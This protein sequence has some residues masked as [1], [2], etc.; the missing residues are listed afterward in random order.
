MDHRST[1]PH[2][3]SQ[4][5]HPAAS[6][7]STPRRRSHSQPVAPAAV[8]HLA[9]PYPGP[10][11]H[12]NRAIQ[13]A[14]QFDF[15]AFLHQV[16]TGP[17]GYDEDLFAQ[18]AS[19]SDEQHRQLPTAPSSSSAFQPPHTMP[20]LPPQLQQL[21][22]QH[23][24]GSGGQAP[25]PLLTQTFLAWLQYMHLQNQLSH[26]NPQQP[27]PHP[28]GAPTHQQQPFL[29]PNIPQTQGYPQTLQLDASTSQAGPSAPRQRRASTATQPQATDSPGSEP[30]DGEG[31]QI[32][33]AEDKRRRNTA[34]SARFRVKKKQWTLNLERS[35]TDLSGRVEELEREAAELRRENGW[36]KEIVMLKS[37]RFG[38]GA[39]SAEQEAS[40]SSSEE[41]RDE[42]DREGEGSAEQDEESHHSSSAGPDPVVGKG[43]GRDI[44]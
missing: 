35:I 31:D 24:Q 14:D 42:L 18:L 10:T 28:S 16:P 21:Q 22:H 13:P 36:L 7:N 2:P 11:S 38:S 32:V 37:K 27:Q 23:Q 34:A 30:N 12:L 6:G 9:N 29:Y 17:E 40:P 1:H 19:M 26:G 8:A 41:R 15:E 5:S 20:V 39:G 44:S 3:T 4:H 33:I 25:N 43:K